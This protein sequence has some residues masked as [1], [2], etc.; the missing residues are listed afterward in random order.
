M[1]R[2]SS[3]TSLYFLMFH[4]FLCSEIGVEMD[5]SVDHQQNS[6]LQELAFLDHDL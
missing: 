1:E 4:I 5:I 6:P 2:L 3:L